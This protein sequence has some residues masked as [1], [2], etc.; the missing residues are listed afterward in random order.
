MVAV[1]MGELLQE[2]VLWLSCPGLRGL[3]TVAIDALLF[4]TAVSAGHP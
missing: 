4:V 2:M 1:T 3:N